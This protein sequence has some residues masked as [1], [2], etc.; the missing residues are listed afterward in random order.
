[1]TIRQLFIGLPILI[2]GWLAVLVGMGFVSDS[3]PAQMILFP[4]S[5]LIPSLASDVAIIDSSPVSVTVAST[6]SDF[7]KSLYA[8]GALL[9][10][11][12]GLPGCSGPVT[13]S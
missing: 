3:A 13:R 8:A 1:M 2:C 12:A 9:V 6:G 7:V 11:P 5:G 10:L 4:P